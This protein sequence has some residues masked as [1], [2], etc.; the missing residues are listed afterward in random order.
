MDKIIYVY[1]LGILTEIFSITDKYFLIFIFVFITI[2]FL[3]FKIYK[4]QIK[5]TLLLF[6]IFIFA[7]FYTKYELGSVSYK[8]LN[9]G[10]YE[11]TGKVEQVKHTN[12]TRILTVRV[13][14]LYNLNENLAVENIPEY[15]NV[16]VS[17]LNEIQIFEK[18]KV[19]GEINFNNPRVY[20][21]KKPM[22]L[23]YEFMK[24]TENVFYS[25]SFPKNISQI[26]Y[27]KKFYETIIFK[28][29]EASEDLRNQIPKHM[30]EPYASIAE[31]ISLGNQENLLKDIK[32]IFKNSGL[33]HIL[34]LS[35]ANVMF[36]ISLVW[37]SLQ[38]VKNK[39]LKIFSAVTFSWIFIF[40]T[41]TTAP[42]VRAGVMS[43][44]NILAEFFSKNISNS[45]SLLLSLF[46]LTLIS[47]LSL[48][49]SPSLH[50]S[51]LACVALFIVAP[52]IENFLLEKFSHNYKYLKF[53]FANFVAIFVCI[54]PYILALT[55][56]ASLFGTLLTFLIDPFIMFT[57]ILS[58]LIIL[59]SYVNFYL[60]DFFGLLNIFSTKVILS[61][62]K[63]GAENLPITNFEISKAE[64]LIYYTI[65][66]FILNSNKFKIKKKN[67]KLLINAKV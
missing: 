31:G 56:Q 7:V 61:V 24:L 33:M 22:F 18:V 13:E 17:P 65:L 6:F 50:L 25:V 66:F 11:I 35:G 2:L 32:D 34:V 67:A 58:L 4:G 54:T 59:S 46:I 28:F 38:K 9:N 60:A 16:A 12:E 41:G 23:N 30:S 48:V 26:P 40:I 10:T 43:T 57:T 47:P 49:Y 21:D 62:A 64:L 42:S 44:T 63:F 27:E 39:F 5:N 51:F 1:L 52:K 37:Y 15:I 36:V 55:E 8:N 3:T 20:I 14:N 45:Y 19:V 29:H 53:I